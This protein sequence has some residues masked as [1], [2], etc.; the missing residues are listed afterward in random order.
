[1]AVAVDGVVATV[2]VAVAATVMEMLKK[3]RWE[4]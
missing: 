3:W 4:A 1:M 2:E